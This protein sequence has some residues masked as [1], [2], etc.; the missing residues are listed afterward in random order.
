VNAI[1][2]ATVRRRIAARAFR[3]SGGG[4][5][6]QTVPGGHG[7]TFVRMQA[8]T[9]QSLSMAIDLMRTPGSSFTTSG[10]VQYV[11]VFRSRSN[12]AQR[13]FGPISNHHAVVVSGET[14]NAL[15]VFAACNDSYTLCV[16]E[17]ETVSPSPYV[18]PAL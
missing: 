15:P 12:I 3:P 14:G 17:D 9:G 16:V 13:L 10:E 2:A 4:V 5:Y 1:Q 8:G 18:V 6:T 11:F 7:Y